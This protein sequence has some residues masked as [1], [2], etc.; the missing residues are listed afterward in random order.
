V[1]G[2]RRGGSFGWRMA[3][4]IAA[5]EQHDVGH[6]HLDIDALDAGVGGVFAVRRLADYGDRLALGEIAGDLQQEP[7]EHPKPHTDASTTGAEMAALRKA[8]RDAAIHAGIKDRTECFGVAS[9]AVGRDIS[10]W[11]D[12]SADELR[13]ATDQFETISA[14]EEV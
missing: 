8:A 14:M 11:G 12:M 2:G 7:T 9:A 6:A 3:L 1:I 4:F 5:T 10:D 13:K